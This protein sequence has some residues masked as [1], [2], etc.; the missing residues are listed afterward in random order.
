M[1]ARE[2]AVL[3]TLQSEGKPM[4]PGDIALKAKLDKKEV[5]K[6]ID[7]LRKEGVVASPKRCFYAPV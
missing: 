2:K 5:S 6:I 4:R 7:K 1:D 3:K